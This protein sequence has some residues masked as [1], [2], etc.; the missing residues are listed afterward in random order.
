MNEND[1]KVQWRQHFCNLKEV[2]V[3]SLKLNWFAWQKT[4]KREMRCMC[5]PKGVANSSFWITIKSNKN[6]QT[7]TQ[8]TDPSISQ[9]SSLDSLSIYDFWRLWESFSIIFITIEMLKRIT[10]HE[11]NVTSYVTDKKKHKNSTQ[12]KK[13]FA[14]DCA[15]KVWEENFLLLFSP[16]RKSIFFFFSNFSFWQ[17]K[18]RNFLLFFSISKKNILNFL[19]P[20]VCFHSIAE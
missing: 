17:Q 5:E 15:W 9:I 2:Q 18:L 20:F 6:T 12:E 13:R 1:L 14:R 10:C 16:G 4:M 8:R 19:L 11:R 3:K 7:Q